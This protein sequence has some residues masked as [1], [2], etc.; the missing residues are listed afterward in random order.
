[1][2]AESDFLRDLEH[3]DDRSPRQALLSQLIRHFRVS[4]QDPDTAPSETRRAPRPGRQNAVHR[5]RGQTP[6][7]QRHFMNRT[8]VFTAAPEFTVL[9]GRTE[10]GRTD[11][12]LLTAFHGVR[13]PRQ[14][15][16]RSPPAQ[17]DHGPQTMTATLRPG[18]EIGV[19]GSTS[20]T[21]PSPSAPH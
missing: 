13:P 14:D 1:V 17:E 19:Q 11:P 15:Q 18:P 6:L 20:A 12:T 8:A 2:H 4:A 3:C 7:R 16:D 10:I 5:P 9:N 21:G